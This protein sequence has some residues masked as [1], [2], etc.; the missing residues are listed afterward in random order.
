MGS[1]MGQAAC[2]EIYTGTHAVRGFKRGGVG[3]GRGHI[4]TRRRPPLHNS[5]ANSSQSARKCKYSPLKRIRREG[6]FRFD[7]RVPL[8]LLM[9]T[10]SVCLRSLRQRVTNNSLRRF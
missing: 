6:V 1:G 5:P 3:K 2:G 8:C 9:L 7:L 10:A 4:A